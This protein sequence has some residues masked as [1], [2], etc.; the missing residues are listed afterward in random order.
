MGAFLSYSIVGGFVMLLLYL[1]Y[2]LFLAKD[3]QHAFNRAVL[4]GRYLL[5]FLS[6]L[7]LS[8]F[9]L[10][11]G[12]QLQSVVQTGSAVSG[13]V[14][15]AHPQSVWISMLIWLYVAG[16]A[17]VAI[18]TVAVWFRL[19]SVIRSGKRIERDGYTLVVTEDDRYSPFSWMRYVVVSRNDYESGCPAIETHEQKH[20]AGCHWIDLM[21]AQ[22]VCMIN[23]FN[24]AAW[25]M[26][27]EL[28]LVHEYQADMAV[29]ESGHNPQD[30]QM[31]L[32]RKAVG[33]RFP[34]LANSLNHSKLKKRITMMYKAKSG[35]GQK[36][37]ALALVPMLALALG[38]AGAPVVRAAVST[39]G[40]S[41]ISVGK[42]NENPPQRQIAVRRFKVMNINND[43]VET[44]VVVRGE[45]LGN[46]LTVSG[47]TFT[48][49]GKTYRAKSLRCDMTDGVASITAVFPFSDEFRRCSMTL[50]VN[51]DEIPFELEE[52]FKNSRSA[53]IGS[54]SSS[55]SELKS[56]STQGIASM[57]VDRQNNAI[58]ITSRK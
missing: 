34:S 17:V 31:L 40:S 9:D 7:C 53:A 14:V 21:V 19:A 56:L 36:F 6:P 29:V 54:N 18:R 2:R 43:G 25:L 45:G 37:K 8:M 35:A 52:F 12:R 10:D 22:S 5:S 20:V 28:M 44:T 47:G 42:D 30:Y 1:A 57:V 58:R 46:S 49:K 15:P 38:V 11:G 33:A 39:I 4:L 48:N 23:W 24:P 16:M 51:G 3:N 32:I 50:N 26:R 13:A 41:E 27:D 55:A